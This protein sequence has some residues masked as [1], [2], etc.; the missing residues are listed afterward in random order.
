M[1]LVLGRLDLALYTTAGALCAL[2]GHGLPYARRAR[3]LALLVLGA[4]AGTA[5][6]LTC[7][8]LTDSA[9]LLVPLAS[10]V[11]AAHRVA[12]DVSRVGPPGNVVLTFV[13]SSAFFV[14]QRLGDVPE[15]VGLVA[16]CGALAWAICMAPAAL[17]RTAPAPAPITAPRERGSL[18]LFVRVAVGCAL[19]GW[20][21]LALGVGHPYWSVVTAASVFQA[22]AAPSRRRAAQR[23]LGNVLG[24]ALFAA[25]LPLARTGEAALVLVALALQVGAE[26][27]ISR[28]YWLGSV[29]VTPMALLLGEFAGPHRAGPLVTDRLVDTLVGA[30]LGLLACALTAP[31]RARRPRAE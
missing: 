27:F 26:A 8:A 13:T 16:V 30:A 5:F 25:L 31:R 1:L 14:P 15:H 22:G 2:Y 18:A 9:A 24:L 17:R 3:T 6:A 23:V 11:A 28:N 7:A 4:V 21:S 10:L 12:C 29:C 19:A 20:A